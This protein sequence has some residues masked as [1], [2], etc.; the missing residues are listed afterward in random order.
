MN[1]SQN[2]LL[3][4]YSPMR[5]FHPLAAAAVQQG[6]KIYHLNIGQPDIKTPETFFQAVRNFKQEVLA[7]SPSQGIPEMIEAV[8]SYYEKMGASF[9]ADDILITT[10]ASEGLL[11][12]M[13]AILD[14]GSEVITPEPFYPNYETCAL[15]AGGALRPI[16]TKPENGYRYATREQIEPLIN[17]KTRAIMLANPSNPTGYILSPEEMRLLADVAIE[18]DLYL[19]ADEVYREFAYG[20]RMPQSFSHFKDL[21]QHLVLVDSASKRFS[22]CG[23]RIGALLTKNK[24]LMAQ[25]MKLAQCRLAVATLDQIAA[26][27]LYSLEPSYFDDVRE[28]YHRRRDICYQK[29]MEIPGVCCECPEG[30]FYMMAKLPV[31]DTDAFQKWLLEEFED[32]GE[33]VMFAPGSGFYTTPGCGNQEI[34][35]AYVLEGKKLARAMELLAIAIAQYNQRN[36]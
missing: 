10:G 17:K 15:I 11:F 26:T 20:D 25:M 33:T 2:V 23:A 18:N 7:Y 34:R 22:A 1:L 3:C 8:R 21:E 31:D 19:I 16:M 30:A 24:E 12:L 32:N 9:T 14:A 5:K 6:K 4:E 29:L 36:K 13:Q 28:E 27:A 35:I